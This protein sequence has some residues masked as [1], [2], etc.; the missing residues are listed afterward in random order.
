MGKWLSGT[1]MAEN[2]GVEI[3]DL[4]QTAGSI[5]AGSKNYWTLKTAETAGSGNCWE[6][7]LQ[8]ADNCWE[9]TTAGSRQLLRS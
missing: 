2:L 7:T 3:V 4:C 1:P 9:R 8:G 5:I 6:R